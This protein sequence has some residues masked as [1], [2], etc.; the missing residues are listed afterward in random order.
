MFAAWVSGSDRTCLYSGEV[1]SELR[2]EAKRRTC[3]KTRR[4]SQSR[5][6]SSNRST[7]YLRRI[8]GHLSIGE[9]E[10]SVLHTVSNLLEPLVERDLSG[11]DIEP[12]HLLE[13]V[14]RVL[15]D[16]TIK[17]EDKPAALLTRLR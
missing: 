16:D 11:P 3:L 4:R 14:K 2:R 9:I 7:P 6:R 15:A 12:T 10:H 5:P 8:S 1:G 13:Q 17:P